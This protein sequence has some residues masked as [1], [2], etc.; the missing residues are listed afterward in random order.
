M[1]IF[2]QNSA[3]ICLCR[4]LWGCKRRVHRLFTLV[5]MWCNAQRIFTFYIR[6]LTPHQQLGWRL[7]CGLTTGGSVAW[8]DA[9]KK[10][11]TGGKKKSSNPF[12]SVYPRLI[13][14]RWINLQLNTVDQHRERYSTVVF[15][16]T[17]TQACAYTHTQMADKQKGWCTIWRWT[18]QTCGNTNT[19]SH[20]E[21]LH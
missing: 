20:R 9:V 1:K 21:C 16:H 19:H 11:L 15:I 5:N 2:W 18:S 14:A 6:T 10:G 13:S 4:R 7:I 12:C 3:I 17:H 8:S